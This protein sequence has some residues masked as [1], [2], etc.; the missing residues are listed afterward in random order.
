M[1]YQATDRHRRR[2]I[3]QDG[4]F[5]YGVYRIRMD[6]HVATWRLGRLA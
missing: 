5:M 3:R 4:D 6:R 2:R 1:A